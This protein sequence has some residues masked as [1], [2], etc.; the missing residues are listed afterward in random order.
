MKGGP[1]LLCMYRSGVVIIF[2]AA[3]DGQNIFLSSLNTR[4]L[5]KVRH[6]YYFTWE[7]LVVE[8]FEIVAN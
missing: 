7:L 1:L 4:C 6:F 2:V 5:I 3:D 8:V